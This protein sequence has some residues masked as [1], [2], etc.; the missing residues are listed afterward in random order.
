[1]NIRETLIAAA[2]GMSLL[3]STATAGGPVIEDAYEAEP[4]PGLTAGEGLALAAGLLLIIAIASGGGNP[5][6][7]DP[8]PQPEPELGCR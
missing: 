6:N 5:C 3:S 7:G 8:E 1:M 4:A 2:V